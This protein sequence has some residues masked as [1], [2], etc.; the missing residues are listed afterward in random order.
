MRQN[1][2][3]WLRRGHAARHAELGADVV[4]AGGCSVSRQ[5]DLREVPALLGLILGEGGGIKIGLGNGDIEDT[6]ASGNGDWDCGVD[7]CFGRCRAGKY[8]HR[9]GGFDK[10]FGQL[11]KSGNSGCRNK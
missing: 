9:E 2:N 8:G 6:G 4:G 11:F 7:T 5:G 10:H 1:L 3:R